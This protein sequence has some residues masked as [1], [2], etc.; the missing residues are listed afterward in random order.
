MPGEKKDSKEVTVGT[1]CKNNG[2]K[3]CYEGEESNTARCLYHPGFPVFHEGMKFWSCCNRKTSEFDQ[4]LAQEGCE[5][6]THLW[7]KPEV[8]G[9]KK[10]CRFDW[11]Q[12]PSTVSLSI[13]AKVAVPEKCTITANRVRCV[14]NIVFDGG[15]SLF[16]KDLVLREEIIL[17]SSSVK[18]LG[19]K[20]EINLKKAEAF[21][22]PTLE[23][24][25]ENGG[26]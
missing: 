24:P 13:F 3:A 15:K 21:S 2:C 7:V 12:T 9:E 14:I 20:V 19:T 26:S 11:H 8:A 4:F 18:M 23:F 5:T 1:S 17:E 22:W 6:G 10:S 25:V 16:E